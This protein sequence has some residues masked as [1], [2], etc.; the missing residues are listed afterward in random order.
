MIKP[1]SN[2]GFT[3]IELLVA[4]TII[5][6]LTTIGIVSFRSTNLRARDGKRKA[7]LE[8]VRA[9]L[10]LY[11]SDDSAGAGK[12]PAGNFSAMTTTVKAAKYLSDPL[13]QDPRNDASSGYIYTYSTPANTAT[14]CLCGRLETTPAAGNSPDI[15]CNNI[16]NMGSGVYYCLVNP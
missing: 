5:A 13:P 6:V 8:Q 4:A 11:R 9:A 3:L 15:T 16:G 10:E 14:Y 1:R 12:Y 2:S 7:D